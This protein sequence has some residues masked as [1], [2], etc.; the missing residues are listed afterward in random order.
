RAGSVVHEDFELA[1]TVR[2]RL[3]LCDARHIRALSRLR[4]CGSLTDEQVEV[5]SRQPSERMEAIFL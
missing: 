3:T 5:I 2:Y 1:A 4:G